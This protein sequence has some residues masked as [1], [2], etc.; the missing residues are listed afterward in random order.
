MSDASLFHSFFDHLPGMAFQV[1]LGHD[2]TLHFNYVSPGSAAVLDISA[3]D[4]M[5]QPQLMLNAIHAEDRE[6]FLLT[7]RRAIF[8]I[9]PWNW[10][11]RIVL[12]RNQEVKWVNLR[13]T[14]RHNSKHVTILEGFMVNITHSKQNE[15]EIVHAHQQLRELSAYIE[16]FK[17]QERGHIAREIH[18]DIGVLLTAVK[19]DL[20]WLTQQLPPDKV[21]LH[22]KSR[23]MADLLDTAVN[24]VNNLIHT[25]RPGVLDHFGIAAAIDIEARDFSRRTGI[26][27]KFSANEEDLQ[28][29]SEQSTSLFRTFQDILGNIMLRSGGHTIRV[30]LGRQ[31]DCVTLSVSDDGKDYDA[32]AHLKQR[33]LGIRIVKLRVSH[34]GG[35]ATIEQDPDKSMHITV[36]LPTSGTNCN[37]CSDYQPKLF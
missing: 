16:D 21:V 9:A 35:C 33:E 11:G 4:L 12:A 10:E 1:Q 26:V 17:E 24:T 3:A 13:A 36:C 28:L 27:C 19:M 31:H 29:S 7:L 22:E 32:G 2:D 37:D 20:S 15:M 34:L 25:L 30:G 14:C 23:A 6:R 18:D 5:Q 8:N